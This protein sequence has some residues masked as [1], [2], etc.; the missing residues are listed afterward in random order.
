MTHIVIVG[1][2]VGGLELA[3]ALGRKLGRK[4]TAEVTL[5]DRNHTHIW[6][7]L[8]HEVASGSLD[9]E[10][11]AVNYRV[12]AHRNG[13]HFELGTLCG[14]D[15]SHKRI[16][17]APLVDDTGDEILPHREKAYDYLVLAVGSVSN[18]FNVEGVSQHC[19]FLDSPGQAQVF[20]Q[21]LVDRFIRLD[22]ELESGQVDRKLRIAIVGG[23]A[24]GVE[25]SAE[26]FKAR[27]WFSTYGLKTIT[28]NHL[29]VSL[30]EAG[31]RLL[32]ALN[33]RISAGAHRELLKLGV[34]VRV[35]TA[36][37]SASKEGL[38]TKEGELIRADLM[39]WA[40]GVKAPGYLA[41]I[42]GV[43]T[44]RMGQLLVE[45]TLQL[46]GDPDIYALGDC[47]GFGMTGPDG[48]QR[49]VPPRAQSAH[50]MAACI[51][52]NL[53]RRLKDKPQ[54]PFQYKDMGSLVSLS[55]YSAFGRLMGGLARGGI[56]LEGK[57]ARLAYVSL[58]RMHQAAIHGWPRAMLLA[59][60]DK[61]NHFIRPRFK[62]H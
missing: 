26:L 44:N 3:T 24:T 19:I 45:P 6:K 34:K 17:L 54:Q 61:I 42:E 21:R 35:A 5:I 51:A 43:E 12:H 4:G 8:L 49:W 55:E 39:V 10:L 29:E 22:Q 32:P 11:D 60:T 40:A 53:R 62:L 18:D 46:K 14:V 7:P 59:F 2:G 33:E 48:E 47:A 50:Q 56:S 57:V 13:F 1:G 38:T 36:V 9:A 23:G 25:L 58:Y 16:Q 52:S 28:P 27:E 41:G 37:V 20:H 31:P 15:R 30:I